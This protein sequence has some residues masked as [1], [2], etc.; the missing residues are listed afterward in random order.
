MSKKIIA[1]SILASPIIA[2]LVVCTLD[3]GWVY[4]VTVFGGFGIF[5][6]GIWALRVLG[7]F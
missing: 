1:V 6:L 5:F 7:A 2:I 4:L 3:L